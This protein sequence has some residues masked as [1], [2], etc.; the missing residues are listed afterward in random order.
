MSLFN[1]FTVNDKTK[2]LST[3]QRLEQICINIMDVYIEMTFKFW[4]NEIK[5]M[6]A[7]LK[8]KI[9]ISRNRQIIFKFFIQFTFFTFVHSWSQR[10]NS[11]YL[12]THNPKKNKIKMHLPF[13]FQ[14]FSHLFFFSKLILRCMMKW[15][16]MVWTHDVGG[17]LYVPL[18]LILKPFECTYSAVKT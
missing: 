3:I 18:G 7:L 11:L 10:Q 8:Y 16:D 17:C 2:T 6:I 12:S 13:S 5:K 4:L 1:E 15:S 9:P 14:Y